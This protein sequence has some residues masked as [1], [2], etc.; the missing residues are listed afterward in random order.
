MGK[1]FAI[2]TPQVEGLTPY[3][4]DMVRHG[5]HYRLWVRDQRQYW[6]DEHISTHTACVKLLQRFETV[7]NG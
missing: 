3:F 5:L 2:T 4:I 6:A 1:I 7:L